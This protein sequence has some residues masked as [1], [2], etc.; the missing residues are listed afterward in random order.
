MA[1]TIEGLMELGLSKSEAE[2][3]VNRN[4]KAAEKQAAAVARA[5][6]RLPKAQAD[7][8]HAS[9]RVAH[10]TKVMQEAGEKVA[11]NT[12]II[13]GEDVSEDTDED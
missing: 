6:K 11:R 12:A 3:I 1:N 13:A 9:A 8:D 5:E 4:A 7:L 10:W 2:R